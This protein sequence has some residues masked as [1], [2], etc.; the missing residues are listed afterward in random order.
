MRAAPSQQT[1]DG[2]RY[3]AVD[4]NGDHP[5]SGKLGPSEVNGFQ[6]TRLIKITPTRRPER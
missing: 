1:V 3:R 5:Q 4:W 6:P 2:A